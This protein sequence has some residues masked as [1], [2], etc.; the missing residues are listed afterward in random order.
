[1]EWLTYGMFTYPYNRDEVS[2]PTVPVY[3]ISVTDVPYDLTLRLRGTD[4]AYEIRP[5][6]AVSGTDVV[7]EHT[8]RRLATYTSYCMNLRSTIYYSQSLGTLSLP[9]TSYSAPRVLQVRR[10]A[11]GTDFQD[12]GTNKWYRPS[13]AGTDR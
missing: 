10:P 8:R 11:T 6:Y 9:R 4:A 13:V 2:P 12:G 3:A 7:W 5:A 1:M